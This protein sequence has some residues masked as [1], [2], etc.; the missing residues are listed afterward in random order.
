MTQFTCFIVLLSVLSCMAFKEKVSRKCMQ[1]TKKFI[2]DLNEDI[3]REY[4]AL[5]YD[6]FGKMGSD[7]VGGNMNRPGS[8]SECILANAGDFSGQ[9]CQ[10]MLIQEQTG[11]LVGLC[12]PDSCDEAE[13]EILVAND[14]FKYKDTSLVPPIPSVL[15]HNSTQ[16]IPVSTTKCLKKNGT[17]DA[18]AIVCLF[19][20]SFIVALP[21]GGTIYVALI[22]WKKQKLNLSTAGSNFKSDPNLYGTFLQHDVHQKHANNFSADVESP[23]EHKSGRDVEENNKNH[24]AKRWKDSVENNPVYIVALSGPSY[25][26]VDT[27]LLIGGLLSVKSLFSLIHRA[28]DK[29]TIQLVGTFLLNRLKR[30][31]PLHIFMVCLSIGLL[32][33]V[34][35][36][37]FWSF[38]EMQI[39]ICKKYWWTN[40]LLINNLFFYPNSCIPWSW[41]LAIDVQFYFT[42][43]LLVFLLRR[44]TYTLIAVATIFLLIPCF[45]SA[46]LTAYFQLPLYLPN[47]W[48]HKAYFEYYYNKP[49]SR[50]GPYLI[51]IL[52]GMFMNAKKERLLKKQWQAAVGWISS[53]TSMALLVALAYVLHEVPNCPSAPHAIYQGLHRTLWAVAVAWIIF[54]C[55]EGFG[56]YINTFL[57]LN[58]WIPFSSI[59]FACFM[60]HPLLIIIFNGI[61]ETLFHY[62][63]INFFYLYM[64]HLVLTVALGYVLT[65]LVEKPYLFLKRHMK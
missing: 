20:C 62:T 5:M 59:S 56:G 26:A 8:F 33:V 15:L 48:I 30:I 40:M 6:A 27:F 43:P 1:D 60:I 34:P 50:Y 31:Q 42:T 29:M 41:Y 36:G 28:D 47:E 3:P 45:I 16:Q 22:K 7:F 14:V 32:S 21:L 55:D 64:G 51:G 4:A 17:P 10:V 46:L 12:V 35:K 18:S 25:L 52:L 65:V 13:I 23:T 57:S 19:V 54:A 63:D 37:S 49:Y 38:A 11:Y 39:D 24:N 9:Y 58:V 61:Q 53:L 44:N 2:E